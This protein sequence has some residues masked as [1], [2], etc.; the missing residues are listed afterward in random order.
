MWDEL[1]FFFNYRVRGAATRTAERMTMW[2]AWH[3]PKSLRTWIVVRAF[4][5]ATTTPPGDHLTPNE[6]GYDLVMKAMR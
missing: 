5:D 4:A 1:P 3:L 2:V 6:V